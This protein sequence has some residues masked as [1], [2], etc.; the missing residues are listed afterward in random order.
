MGLSRLSAMMMQGNET[1]C[2]A[3]GPYDNGKYGGYIYMLR[4]GEIHTPI[5][6]VD[7]G[8]YKSAEE[9]VEQLE[10]LVKEVRELDL[11]AEEKET[12]GN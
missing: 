3:Q 6:S 1:L 12:D 4:D 11:N 10:D 7:Y 8:Y 5:V 9:A 2:E